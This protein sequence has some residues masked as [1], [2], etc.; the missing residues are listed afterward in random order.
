ML[1]HY[2]SER[3]YYD[4][5]SSSDASRILKFYES[6]K[7]IFEPYDTDRPS[8]F[9]TLEYQESLARLENEHFL[10]G[11]SARFWI[12]R[13]NQPGTIIGC[14]SFNNILKG[15]FL[16]CTIGYKISEAHHHMGYATEAIQFLTSRFFEDGF[17]HRVDAYIH[18][19]N[20]PSIALIERCGFVCE[21]VSREYAYLHG[22]WQDHLHFSRLAN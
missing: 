2:E 5:L 1:Y 12:T 10:H 16:S 22:K 19:D 9:Y 7:H 15:S 3:L 14:V 4:I 21:G 13:R 11:D 20:K 18:P 6:N 17:L 8:N